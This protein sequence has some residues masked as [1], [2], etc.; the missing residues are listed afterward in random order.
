MILEIKIEQRMQIML[1][2][3]IRPERRYS[4]LHSDIRCYVRYKI[5]MVN[6][7]NINKLR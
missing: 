1:L 5:Y 7:I 3:M 2:C 4:V 6:R